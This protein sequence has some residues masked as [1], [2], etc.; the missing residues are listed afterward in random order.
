MRHTSFNQNHFL[1]VRICGKKSPSI[2]PEWRRP[3]I[4]ETEEKHRRHKN[5]GNGHT[6]VFIKTTCFTMKRRHKDNQARSFCIKNTSHIDLSSGSFF[7][8]RLCLANSYRRSWNNTLFYT[9]TKNND[10]DHAAD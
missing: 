3:K 7:V 8:G 5:I 4:T 9:N 10:T 1:E 2:L 6:L